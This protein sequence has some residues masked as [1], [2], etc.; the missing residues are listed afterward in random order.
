M[1]YQEFIKNIYTSLKSINL[2]HQKI[3]EQFKLTN[4]KLETLENNINNVSN[5]LDDFINTHNRAKQENNIEFSNSLENVVSNLS[6]IQEEQKDIFSTM[7]NVKNID[8]ENNMS[9]LMDEYLISEPNIFVDNLEEDTNILSMNTSFTNISDI[10]NNQV[11]NNKT[12][13]STESLEEI[14]NIEELNNNDKIHN[15]EE[16]NN[17]EEINNNEK[18][19]YTELTKKIPEDDLLILE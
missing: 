12:I 7:Q 6:I 8:I 3:E 16:L 4:D 1:N 18:K 17:V 10:E 19:E 9:V 15:I 5:K 14:P 11:S 13:E 2:K